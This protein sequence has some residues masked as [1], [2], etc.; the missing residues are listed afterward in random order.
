[1]AVFAGIVAGGAYDIISRWKT[2]TNALQSVTASLERYEGWMRQN[3]PAI[4]LDKLADQDKKRLSREGAFY[5][6]SIRE[7]GYR[8]YGIRV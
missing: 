8:E 2:R 7:D 3:A 6:S 5:L 1:M 4:P